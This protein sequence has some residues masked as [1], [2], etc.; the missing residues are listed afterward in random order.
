MK[1]I[2]ATTPALITRLN[3]ALDRAE[4]ALAFD[5]EDGRQGGCADCMRIAALDLPGDE[6]YCPTHAEVM[7]DARL[8]GL[9]HAAVRQFDRLVLADLLVMEVDR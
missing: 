8:I 3:A 6:G 4:S 2:T 9:L 5:A 7:A 1:T